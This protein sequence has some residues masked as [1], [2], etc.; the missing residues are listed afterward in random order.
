MKSRHRPA[1][2]NIYT[3][4][5]HNKGAALD[6]F[7]FVDG[8]VRPICRPIENQRI[9]YNGHKRVH[10]LT[11]HPI[12]LPNSLIGHMYGS[13]DKNM[14]FSYILKSPSQIVFSVLSICVSILFC[15]TEERCMMSRCPAP[16][17]GQKAK[18]SKF[19]CR[20]DSL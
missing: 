13:A 15:L 5:I 1:S 2:M 17:A 4:A 3:D 9:V 11:F 14:S 12:A 16:P 7:A 18:F 20:R 6:C 10:A 8:T 19:S